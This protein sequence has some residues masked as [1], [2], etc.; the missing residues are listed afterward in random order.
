MPSD[1]ALN[2]GQDEPFQEDRVRKTASR[3]GRKYLLRFPPHIRKQYEEDL[4]E[5]AIEVSNRCLR[6][7]PHH[8]PTALV[9]KITKRV[10]VDRMRWHRT[11]GGGDLNLLPE[12]FDLADYRHQQDA[13]GQTA[14]V[15]FKRHIEALA[16]LA[17]ETRQQFKG[18]NH[19]SGQSPEKTQQLENQLS[20]IDWLRHEI[21]SGQPGESKQKNIDLPHNRSAA[22]ISTTLKVIRLQVL[23]K[24]LTHSDSLNTIVCLPLPPDLSDSFSAP[25][26]SWESYDGK[27]RDVKLLEGGLLVAVRVP[28]I[29][30][31]IADGA[32]QIR[33]VVR[34]TV[35]VRW[36]HDELPPGQPNL[37]HVTWEGLSSIVNDRRQFSAEDQP[38]GLPVVLQPDS[39]PHA[40]AAILKLHYSA[41][42]RHDNGETD[43]S[44]RKGG[45]TVPRLTVRCSVKCN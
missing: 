2:I 20:L 42:H 28:E 36:R 14:S 26:R 25:Y 34:G 45:S 9:N 21:L 1:N 3:C 31:E 8:P 5:L 29:S 13:T 17:E 27:G 4:E 22:T 35:L 19:D 16:E 24:V 44:Q 40:D 39:A 6:Q 12:D 10:I 23:T 38:W 37:V 32:N 7:S 18:P 15:L 43:I 11:H 33:N 30:L 41:R